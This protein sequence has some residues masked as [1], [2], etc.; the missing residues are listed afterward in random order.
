MNWTTFYGTSIPSH[1]LSHQH[2]SNIHWYHEIV[3][4]REVPIM[5]KAE[6]AL[7]FGGIRLPYRPLHSFPYEIDFLFANGFITDKLE[8][9]VVVYGKW[10]GEL[11]YQ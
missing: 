6:L 10:V 7:R 11:S 3:L 1:K 8:S 5:A 9:N 4:E 2:L